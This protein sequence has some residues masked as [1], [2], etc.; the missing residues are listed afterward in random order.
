MKFDRLIN[1][2]NQ[3]LN[4][5]VKNCGNIYIKSKEHNKM[6]TFFTTLQTYEVHRPH[7]F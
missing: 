6:L 7:S 4:E 5:C 3:G 2:A 1:N